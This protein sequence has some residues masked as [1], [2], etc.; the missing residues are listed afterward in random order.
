[1]TGVQ[2]CALPICTFHS[3][4]HGYSYYV[5]VE[6]AIIRE[7]ISLSRILSSLFKFAIYNL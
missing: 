1:V 3:I 2:T 4:K 6:Y 5:I 7:G